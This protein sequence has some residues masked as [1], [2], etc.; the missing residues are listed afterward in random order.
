MSSGGWRVER[1][2]GSAAAFHARAMPPAGGAERVV[3]VLDVDGAAL[4]LGSTQPGTDVDAAAARAA[5]VEVVRRRSGGGAVLLEPG[6]ASWV[7]VDLPAGD[8]LWRTDVAEAFLWLGEAWVAALARLG[9]DGVRHPGPLV[10]T[11][12][13]RAVC[14]AGLGPG[15]V[16]VGGRKVVGLAQRRT[17]SAARFQCAVLHRWDPERLLRLLALP[18]A[19]RGEAALALADVAVGVAQP[20][21]DVVD[22]FLSALPDPN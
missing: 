15:E 14:F 6:G 17:R 7:D 5:A 12:W 10:T 8:P 22:A 4:V 11:R 3:R 1:A 9:I 18:P 13:S 20:S 21:G 16:T 19:V 2:I